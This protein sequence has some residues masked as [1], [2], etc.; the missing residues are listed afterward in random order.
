MPELLVL[1]EFQRR[2]ITALPNLPVECKL[3]FNKKTFMKP[4]T[5]TQENPDRIYLYQAHCIQS[6]V[7]LIMNKT[8]SF[9][10]QKHIN[11]T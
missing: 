5:M 10:H 8:H 2:C 7:D 11:I 1:H 9:V 3:V 6:N 4:R